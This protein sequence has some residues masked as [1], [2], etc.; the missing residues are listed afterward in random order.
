[1]KCDGFEAVINDLAKTVLMDA[2][3]RDEALSH[4]ASCRRCAMRLAD[5]RELTAG[6]K[7]LA[8]ASAGEAP[9]RIEAS[10]LAVFREQRAALPVSIESRRATH[11]LIYVAAG[12]AAVV[13]IVLL[14]SLTISRTRVSNQV[15]KPEQASVNA[16]VPDQHQQ[17]N[18]NP[19]EVPAPPEQRRAI[20]KSAAIDA[21]SGRVK[22]PAGSKSEADPAAGSNVEAEIATDFFP[23]INRGTGQLD[24]GQVVR[25]ELP[26][27]AMMAFGLPM[28]MDRADER[29][30]ADVVVGNDGLA[31][32]IR[33]VR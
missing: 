7:A 4:S 1:M 19:A 6:L 2:A 25:V 15:Q 24:S 27:S 22:K 29:I 28:N 23:L 32:A 14:V 17:P 13:A 16:P 12:V 11:R 31:R 9:A 20:Q 26:R 3:L 30:K 21:G 5:E 33:F 18:L 10:L 8:V